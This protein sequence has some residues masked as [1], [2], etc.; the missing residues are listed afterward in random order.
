MCGLI[1]AVGDV[2]HND[3][4]MLR[5]LFILDTTRGEDSTGLAAVPRDKN[6]QVE[7]AKEVGIPYNM[8]DTFDIFNHRGE[9]QK[10]GEYRA[11]IGHNRWATT[12][13][14]T[15]E[16]AHPFH[17]GKIIGAHNGTLKSVYRLEDG[18]KFD[19]DSEAIFHNLNIKGIDETIPNIYG[20][21]ALTWWDAE[22]EKVYIIRNKERPLFYTRR[23]DGDVIYWA[24]ERWMLTVAAMKSNVEIGEIHSFET[25]KLYSID[26]KNFNRMDFR[27]KDFVVEK[28]IHGYTPQVVA[29]SYPFP[30]RNRQYWDNFWE[31]LDEKIGKKKVSTPTIPTYNATKRDAPSGTNVIGGSM[32]LS[33]LRSLKGKT[34]YFQVNDECM[35]FSGLH[36]ILANPSDGRDFELRLFIENPNLYQRLTKNITEWSATIKNAVEITGKN[37]VVERYVTVDNRTIVEVVL[38]RPGDKGEGA[39]EDL[40]PP[41]QKATTPTSNKYIGWRNCELTE[42]QF[43]EAT[44]RGC[45][46]CSASIVKEDNGKLAWLAGNEC[47]CPMCTDDEEVR[48]YLRMANATGID[49]VLQ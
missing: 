10:P 18:H 8:F 19:V 44:N 6:K 7:I 37:G 31:E 28:E 43:I 12:G 22:E 48:S 1:G 30:Q 38:D 41:F 9:I 24:S 25:D 46:W 36:Y 26:L 49:L 21:Y 29:T 33:D 47:I 17:Q 27:K 3:T 42:L 23:K 40:N 14:V 11:F 2:M 13:K 35:G 39:K 45:A 4:K 32:P 34:V 5:T 15:A 20:A 16:N